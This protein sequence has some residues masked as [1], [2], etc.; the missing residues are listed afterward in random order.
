MSRDEIE[1]TGERGLY[2]RIVNSANGYDTSVLVV[3]VRIVNSS[4]CS[5]A[6]IE[7]NTPGRRAKL[8]STMPTR[9]MGHDFQWPNR[10]NPAYRLVIIALTVCDIGT[11][12]WAVA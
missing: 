6:L 9:Q 2:S 11:T 1:W 7:T 3:H 12:I 5:R 8:P 10:Q 4:Y